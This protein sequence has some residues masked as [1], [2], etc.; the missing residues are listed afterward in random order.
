MASHHIHCSSSQE[1][2]SCW[3]GTWIQEMAFVTEQSWYLRNHWTTRF[4]NVWFLDLTGLSWFQESSLFQ[5]KENTP[6]NGTG[7]SFQS[8]LH[9]PPQLT[10]PKV[11]QNR[12]ISFINFINIRTN[13]ETCWSLA[14]ISDLFPWSAV[15]CM[16]TSWKAWISEVCYQ[17]EG[18]WSH[19]GYSKCC[20]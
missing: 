3:S 12:N 5:R 14:Q 8:N 9:L 6:L 1:C 18:W 4:F 20:L 2:H 16:F 10:S 19:W 13:F 15:C 11:N 7:D 17:E